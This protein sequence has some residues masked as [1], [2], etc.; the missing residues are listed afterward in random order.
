MFGNGLAT[1]FVAG[2]LLIVN[3]K[4]IK[5]NDT[6]FVGLQKFQVIK[7]S[8]S[9][10]SELKCSKFWYKIDLYTIIDGNDCI[11]LQNLY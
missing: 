1:C 7:N 9:I 11:H 6:T 10:F 8:V 5:K 4:I 3:S 2:S